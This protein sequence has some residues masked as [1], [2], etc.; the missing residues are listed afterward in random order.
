M[1]LCHVWQGSAVV[2]EQ[3]CS[4]SRGRKIDSGLFW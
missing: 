1:M 2:V 4:C 3:V